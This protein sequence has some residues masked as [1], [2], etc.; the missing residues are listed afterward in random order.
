MTT[1]LYFLQSKEKSNYLRH[2]YVSYRINYKIEAKSILEEIF[3]FSM[4]IHLYNNFRRTLSRGNNCLMI[5]NNFHVCASEMLLIESMRMKVYII[6]MNQTV[7][8]EKR[9]ILCNYIL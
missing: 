4:L 2:I 3:P 5:L 7:N 1:N 8:N 6:Q 9:L